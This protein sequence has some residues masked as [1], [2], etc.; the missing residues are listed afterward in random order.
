MY[1]SFVPWSLA[2][3]RC[4]RV[5]PMHTGKSKKEKKNEGKEERGMKGK[6]KEKKVKSLGR[7][8]LSHQ[9]GGSLGRR[10]REGERETKKE[11][12]EGAE[13]RKKWRAVWSNWVIRFNTEE[14]RKSTLMS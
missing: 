3:S 13:E 11:R 6:E 14:V 10:E 4:S 12:K 7:V 1:L 5:T 8:C 9:G 2:H